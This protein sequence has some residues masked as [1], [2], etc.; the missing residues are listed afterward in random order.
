[1]LPDM[2]QRVEQFSSR[3]LMVLGGFALDR[4]RY[5]QAESI[6]PE[7]PV[8][9]LRIR[10][11]IQRP[12]SAG[13]VAASLAALGAE[14]VCCG[15]IGDDRSGKQLTDLLDRAGVQTDSLTT[16]PGRRTTTHTRLIGLAQSRH[17]QQMLRVE[18]AEPESLPEQTVARVAA[19]LTDLAGQVDAICLRDSE[20][21]DWPESLCLRAIEAGRQAGCPVL[22]RPP[23]G[24]DWQRY[25]G[26]T[27]L[28]ANRRK[29]A[30]RTG[31]TTSHIPRIA[32]LA[33][34]IVDELDL[35]AI[36]VTLD[37]DGAVVV[38]REGDHIHVPTRPRT[39]YDI[40]GAGDVMLAVLG[41]S[42]AAG[43]DWAQ[44]VHLANVGAGLSVERF[45]P[46]A[47][48]RDEMLA[49]LTTDGR[50]GVGK[51]RTL[52]ELTA[53]LAPRRTAGSKVVFTNGCFD[54]LHSGHIQY[55]KFCREQGDILVVGL[56]S[57]ESVRAQDKGDGRPI[58]TQIDR[59]QMLSALEDIDYVVIF[60]EPT[61]ENMIRRILPD[62]L[63]KGAD[64][65]K[66]V[67]GREIVEA[68]G[69]K[70]ILAPVL[71]GYSTTQLIERIKGMEA[72]RERDD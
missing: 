54:I 9:V 50:G 34:R 24:V 32:E 67:C 35:R 61:P 70:V 63:V 65:A 27:C 31:E 71:D 23:S 30:M 46:V 4:H 16:V 40:T 29:L 45:G 14:V 60:D 66:W 8:P 41:A 28:T 69:G 7:A 15:A 62:V 12:G 36:V 5:G 51:L 48:S 55:F 68:D 10:D 18:R 43:A 57:D 33:R 11:E 3:R 25:K 39:V 59:T 53:E 64:W 52:D 42:L 47:V 22:V 72:R 21:N 17:P 1:M 37:R 58:N 6:S 26:A 38:P 44:A 19:S 49:D 56:N 2:V 13:H 20:A